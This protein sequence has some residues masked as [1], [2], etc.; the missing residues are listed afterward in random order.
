[1]ASHLPTPAAKNDDV[2]VAERINAISK[3]VVSRT[4]ETVDR[5]NT[6]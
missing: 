6:P 5:H 2:Q 1:M 3:I 4:L